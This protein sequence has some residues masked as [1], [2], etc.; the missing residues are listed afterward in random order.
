MIDFTKSPIMKT[1]YR[2]VG[3]AELALIFDTQM[4]AFP[5]RLPEQ[6]IFY[7]VLNREYAIQ[8]ARNWNAPSKQSGFSGFVTQFSV[9][10]HYLEQFPVQ[11]VGS[12]IHKELWVPAEQLTE[13]NGEIRGNICMTDAFFCDDYT[14]FIPLD[15]GL[16]HRTAVEQFVCL[17]ATLGY[18]GMDFICEISANHKAI[19]LNF[20]FWLSFNFSHHGILLPQRDR[21]LDAIREYWYPRFSLLPLYELC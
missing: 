15:F 2:P 3:L 13:F 20:P 17:S 14:G 18:S 19:Y 10:S 5:P 7:P 8:I 1:L 16:A 12:S 21:V 9:D 4:R 11:T 6:P